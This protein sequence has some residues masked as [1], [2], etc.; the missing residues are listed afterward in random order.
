MR[1]YDYTLIPAR[2]LEIQ[3]HREYQV[4]S[5][6]T[7][8]RTPIDAAIQ[9]ER[10]RSAKVDRIGKIV[11]LSLFSVVV[12]MIVVQWGVALFTPQSQPV[13]VPGDGANFS[14]SVAC[15]NIGD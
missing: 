8:D 14:C 3:K 15:L 4:T 9:Q 6:E 7:G 13:S 11:C 5:F 12:A 2:L 1:D 10:L